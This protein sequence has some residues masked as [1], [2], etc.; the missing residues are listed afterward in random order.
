MGN[1][2][3]CCLEQQKN[4]NKLQTKTVA[5]VPYSLKLVPIEPVKDSFMKEVDLSNFDNYLTKLQT[6]R[7]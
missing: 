7:P 6:I 3:L 4:N 1:V 2:E 5:S